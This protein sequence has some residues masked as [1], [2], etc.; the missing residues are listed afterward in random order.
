M[1]P[2]LIKEIVRE[3]VK[4]AVKP[5]LQRQID[6]T[7]EYVNKAHVEYC[8]RVAAAHPPRDDE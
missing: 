1:I 7:V 6:A 5:R 2:L 3:V 4:D 8:R